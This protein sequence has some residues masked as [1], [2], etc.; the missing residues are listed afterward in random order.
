MLS[1]ENEWPT[2]QRKSWKPLISVSVSLPWQIGHTMSAAV[3][4]TTPLERGEHGRKLPGQGRGR[5][6]HEPR[7]QAGDVAHGRDAIDGRRH[8]DTPRY[9]RFAVQRMSGG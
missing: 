3:P 4:G 9:D 5:L 8:V 7:D 2:W 6:T 1:I